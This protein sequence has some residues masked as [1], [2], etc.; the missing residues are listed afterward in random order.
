M[1]NRIASKQYLQH[2]SKINRLEYINKLVRFNLSFAD[3]VRDSAN[4]SEK[5]FVQTKAVA[6]DKARLMN[7][8][9]DSLQCVFQI[10]SRLDKLENSIDIINYRLDTLVNLIVKLFSK[11]D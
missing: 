6:N 4:K 3:A 11:N 5:L 10:Q 9:T 8:N 2:Q 7:D 1:K